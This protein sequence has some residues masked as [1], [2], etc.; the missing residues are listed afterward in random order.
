MNIHA[1]P[2]DSKTVVV[3]W[4]VS[5]RSSDRLYVRWFLPRDSQ[6]P[7]ARSTDIGSYRTVLWHADSLHALLLHI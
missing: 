5:T 2:H 1:R 4:V 3:W 6:A 7:V